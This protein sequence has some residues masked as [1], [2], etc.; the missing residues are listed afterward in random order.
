MS[1]SDWQWRAV[2]LFHAALETHL[3]DREPRPYVGAMLPI[4][5]RPIGEHGLLRQLAPDV[6]VAPID[7]TGRTS[8]D[9]EREGAPPDFVLEV[10]SPASEER[11]LLLKPAYY[12]A[13]GVQE[14]AIFGPER[15]EQTSL[16]GYRRHDPAGELAPWERD[17]LGRLWS[18][19]IGAWLVRDG[20]M[21]RLQRADGSL[22]P[23]RSEE[24]R[25]L[26]EEQAARQ[27]E[28]T[29]RQQAEA[30]AA[31][32]AERR[33]QLESELARLRAELERRA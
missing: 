3:E 22:V 15:G 7:L 11:D 5:F 17:G 12:D 32:E 19:V 21:L 14:Y 10:V 4:R 26:R 1:M 24:R 9:V 31:E 33:R 29:A 13:L 20:T 28:Q 6:L 23:T 2:D 25:A 30:R 8:Y 16:H 27:R 18:E